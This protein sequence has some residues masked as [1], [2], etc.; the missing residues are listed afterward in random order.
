VVGVPAAL[1]FGDLQPHAALRGEFEGVRKQVLENLLQT[2]GI[3][4]EAASE[5]RIEADLE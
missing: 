1:H 3:G 4:G 2:L 5:I